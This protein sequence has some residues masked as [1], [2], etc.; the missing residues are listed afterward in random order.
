MVGSQSWSS[1]FLNMKCVLLVVFVV[2]CF[3]GF[4]QSVEVLMEEGLRLEQEFKPAE[5]LR[6]YKAI[7]KQDPDHAKSLLHASR[8]TSN[9]ASRIKNVDLKRTKLLEAEKYSR[10]S[11][12]INNADPDAHFSLLVALGLQSE[13]APSAREKIKDAMIIR[14]ECEK[15][16]ALDS[17]YALAY[18][19]LGKWHYEI[20]KL[21]WFERMAC[22]LFFGGMP[23]GVSM[24]ESVRNFNKA[25]ALDP[26]QIII[27]YGHAT[28][29]HY[30]ERDEEAI[31]VLQ[32]A[33][34]LPLR[35][36]DDEERKGKC[37][38]LLKEIKD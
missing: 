4:S 23:E 26:T 37:R 24:E 32:K 36:M 28:V 1:F 3:P 9:E 13:I 17:N 14:D 6:N 21:N 22:D 25:L 7:L 31:A 11:L 34:K 12:E 20:S 18:F 5:A 16:I 27:L 30:E 15:I 35:D 38:E 10:H 2:G 8:M 29:L 33:L 19:V